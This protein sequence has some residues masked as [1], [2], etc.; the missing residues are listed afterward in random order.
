MHF[1][2]D[3]HTCL[4]VA[5]PAD[6]ITLVSVQTPPTS[7]LIRMGS[8]E[9]AVWIGP[10]YVVRSGEYL[11]EQ[12]RPRYYYASAELAHNAGPQPEH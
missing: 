7:L 10:D 3:A 8:C 5:F 2:G 12:I 9:G 6:H 11:L 4:L 1:W